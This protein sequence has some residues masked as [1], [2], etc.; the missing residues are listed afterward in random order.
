MG[1]FDLPGT[2]VF[3]PFTFYVFVQYIYGNSILVW[4]LYHCIPQSL[5]KNKAESLTFQKMDRERSGFVMVS[6]YFV[7]QFLQIYMLDLCGNDRRVQQFH[8]Q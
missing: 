3:I 1:I 5:L 8:Y 4:R 7:M 6:C 2:F